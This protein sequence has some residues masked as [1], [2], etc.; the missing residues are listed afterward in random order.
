M[1]YGLWATVMLCMSPGHRINL[2]PQLLT[3]EPVGISFSVPMIM[4]PADPCLFVKCS[5][6]LGEHAFC[7]TVETMNRT[8]FFQ[9][10]KRQNETT[11][12]L[13]GAAWYATP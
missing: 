3:R 8:I 2:A 9:E 1:Q 5:K 7:L 10:L 12:S 6:K 4:P 11:F 13:M